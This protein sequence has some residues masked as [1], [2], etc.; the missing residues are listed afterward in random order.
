MVEY[1]LNCGNAT[2]GGLLYCYDCW[3]LICIEKEDDPFQ[4]KLDLLSI[5]VENMEVQK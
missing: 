2:C 3:R 4:I 1:C 5:E